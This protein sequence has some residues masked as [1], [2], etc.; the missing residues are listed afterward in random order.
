MKMAKI[1]QNEINKFLQDVEQPEPSL[2]DGGNEKWGSAFGREFG[3]TYETKH[4]PPIDPALV[5]LTINPKEMKTIPTP[6]PAHK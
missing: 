3:S 2:P 4:I 5:L 6:T 1:H